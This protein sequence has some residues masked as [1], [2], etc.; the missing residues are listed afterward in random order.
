VK[1]RSALREKKAAGA[2]KHHCQN[3]PGKLPKKPK[4]ER[5]RHLDH[6]EKN[7]GENC[8]GQ[9]TRQ[10]WD[11]SRALEIRGKGTSKRGIFTIN[12]VQIRTEKIQRAGPG[13]SA[14][15]YLLTTSQYEKTKRH[16]NAKR[17]LH[18]KKR[19]KNRWPRAETTLKEKTV[20]GKK[21]CHAVHSPDQFVPGE[22]RDASMKNRA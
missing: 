4:F 19:L 14:I 9:E 21:P 2:V 13:D 5:V 8:S 15:A 1:K 16:A 10:G 3:L 12:Q 7:R 11:G 6:Q 18:K 22:P 17:R 20:E